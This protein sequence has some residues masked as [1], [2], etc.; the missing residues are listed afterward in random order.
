MLSVYLLNFISTK[1]HSLC[2]MNLIRWHSTVYEFLRS[3]TR[4]FQRLEVLTE[5]FVFFPTVT[6]L[7][8]VVMLIPSLHQVLTVGSPLI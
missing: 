2:T 3:K 7:A 5:T 6:L 4:S 1:A 8:F